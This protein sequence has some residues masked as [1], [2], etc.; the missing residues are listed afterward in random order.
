MG[1]Q[2]GEQLFLIFGKFHLFCLKI[3]LIAQIIFLYTPRGGLR[4]HI[5]K[6]QCG[7][8]ARGKDEQKDTYQ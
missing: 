1:V 6:L 2:N 7:Y 8:K 5:Y 3:F 4:G